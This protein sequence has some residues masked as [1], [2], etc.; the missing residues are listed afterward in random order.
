VERRRKR[1]LRICHENTGTS[2]WGWR[3][4]RQ[5]VSSVMSD[6]W[7]RAA[8]NAWLRTFRGRRG[9]LFAGYGA[10]L[11]VLAACLPQLYFLSDLHPG[12]DPALLA[13]CAL[14]V[15]IGAFAGLVGAYGTAFVI[16]LFG[17]RPKE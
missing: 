9:L 14:D 8:R 12:F 6:R 2:F 16:D 5:W 7:N 1:A 3:S 13:L 4:S 10:A 17:P 11:A 15:L